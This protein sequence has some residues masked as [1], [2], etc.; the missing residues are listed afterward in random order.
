MISRFLSWLDASVL[1][2]GGAFVAVLILDQEV[3]AHT[4]RPGF[5]SAAAATLP[6]LLLAVLVRIASAGDYFGGRVSG[7]E[8]EATKDSIKAM[9]A[10]AMALRREAEALGAADQVEA[11]DLAID[12][13]HVLLDKAHQNV[14][15]AGRVDLRPTLRLLLRW[16]FLT[17]LVGECASL[18]ALGSGGSTATTFSCAVAGL[19]SLFLVLLVMEEDAVMRRQRPQ[20]DVDAEKVSVDSGE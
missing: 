12:E 8:L 17:A 2:V 11:L 20:T 1:V 3:D 10:R 15:E 5:Y 18:A 19:A 14:R 7:Q 9:I 13:T 6:I 4:V 16:A